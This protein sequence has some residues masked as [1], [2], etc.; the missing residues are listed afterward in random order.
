VEATCHPYVLGH[1]V[2]RPRLISALFAQVLATPSNLREVSMRRAVKAG[3]TVCLGC[4]CVSHPSYRTVGLGM[5]LSTASLPCRP[6]ILCGHRRSLANLAWKAPPTPTCWRTPSPTRCRAAALG[7]IAC[8][9][10]INP[11]GR[12][13]NS[14]RFLSPCARSC[15]GACTGSVNVDSTSFCASQSERLSPCHPRQVAQTLTARL[16]GCRFSSGLPMRLTGLRRTSRE[17]QAIV[18]LQVK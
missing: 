10:P 4:P 3:A 8:P 15:G 16:S 12:S 1:P 11:R 2:C 17:A 6:L 13:R 7:D 18:T 14:L 5:G 9:F